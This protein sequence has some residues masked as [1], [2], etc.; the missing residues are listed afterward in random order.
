[1]V[2]ESRESLEAVR[3]EKLRKIEALGRDPWG[4]RFDDHQAIQRVRALE[5]P[6]GANPTP[7]VF[8][9][10]ITVEHAD[11]L[12]IFSVKTGKWTD[13]DANLGRVIGPGAE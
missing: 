10:R 9:N 4:S 6:E 11:H 13:F 1:M 7:V 12:H 3:L 2:D 8:T 5:L